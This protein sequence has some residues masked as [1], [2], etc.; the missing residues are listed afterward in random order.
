MRKEDF[1]ILV[2]DDEKSFLLLLTR[3]LQEAGYT[4]RGMHDPESALESLESFAPHL[5][6]TDLKMPK[7]EGIRFMEEAAQ[8]DAGA[9]FIMITA[10]ATVETAVEAMKKGAVDYIT[11]PL[12][13]PGQLREAVA[14]AFGRKSAVNG[15]SSCRDGLPPLAIIFAGMDEVLRE[16]RDVAPTDATVIIY[17]ETGTG[18]SLI[19]RVLHQLS[20]RSGPFVDINCAAIPETL[21]ESELFGYEKG[22]F[23]GAAAQKKGRFELAGGGTLFLDEVSEM[24]LALQGKFLRVLQ[25]KTFERLGSLVSL[26]TDARVIAATNRNLKE[27]VA[28]RRFREDLYYRLTVYPITLPP[29][30]ARRERFRDIAGHL[31]QGIS[32]R[33]GK[34]LVMTEGAMERLMDYPWPGNIR[35]LENVLERA[36][37]RSRGQQLALPD[38]EA[39]EAPGAAEADAGD[40]KSL[41]RA[42]IENALR[43]TRGNRREAAEILGISLRTLQYRIKEYGISG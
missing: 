37:I 5:I 16:V 25:D 1:R 40:L 9:D 33:F 22:A 32:A 2:V 18:K 39:H 43:R 24:S 35:E 41:E 13:D 12:K 21:L 23:T 36:V 29:L 42:A 14:K 4:V 8:R 15:P 7:M 3:I 31:L 20:G 27:C 30:R 26:R 34:D 28:E 10:F 11:K 6:I 17:G 19:A 38:L